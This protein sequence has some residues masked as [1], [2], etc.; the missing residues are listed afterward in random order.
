MEESKQQAIRDR[1]VVDFV[2]ISVLVR[3]VRK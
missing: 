2:S 1:G 3:G